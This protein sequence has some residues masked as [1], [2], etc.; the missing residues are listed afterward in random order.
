VKSQTKHQASPKLL[1]SNNLRGSTG[2]RHETP[3]HNRSAA[4]TQRRAW[5]I[6]ASHGKTI[7]T[8]GELPCLTF[9]QRI[10]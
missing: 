8:Q 6:R 4:E 1:C 3:D 10:S 7:P 5:Q 9:A 2:T